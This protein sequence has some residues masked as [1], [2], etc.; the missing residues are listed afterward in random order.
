M[1]ITIWIFDSPKSFPTK[2]ISF[3]AMLILIMY[4]SI[5]N[6]HDIS[7]INSLYSRL[8]SKS[9]N[10]DEKR[11]Y[12]IKNGINAISKLKVQLIGTG[13]KAFYPYIIKKNIAEGPLW[14]FNEESADRIHNVP[15]I[16]AVEGGLFIFCL[17][18]CITLLIWYKSFRMYKILKKSKFNYFGVYSIVIISALFFPIQVYN[19]TISYQVFYF[20]SVI[21]CNG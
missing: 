13:L 20:L 14:E 18:I 17:F 16:Y 19:S 5:H 2:F 3:L 4:F 8:E 11:I 1:I 21:F 15:L 7:Y 9:D 12:M 6:Y 10:S